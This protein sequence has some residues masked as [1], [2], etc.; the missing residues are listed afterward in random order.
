MG[1][2]RKMIKNIPIVGPIAGRIYR[3]W[4]TPPK[5]FQGSERYWEHRYESGGHSGD[6]SYGR[7]AEFKAEIL[8]A[9]VLRNGIASVIEYGCGDG[10][11]LGLSRYPAYI[12]FDVSANAVSR[13]RERFSG[14]DTKTFKLMTEYGGETAE[15]TLSLDVL[16]HLVEENVFLEY[17][18]RLFD[19]LRGIYQEK[20]ALI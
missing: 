9:F 17:M 4:L 5:P 13:C 16:Y 15:L 14:D 19:S 8:N 18:N 20:L 6:G 12:G 1:A 2:M 11:Q 3:M 10:N 7:L